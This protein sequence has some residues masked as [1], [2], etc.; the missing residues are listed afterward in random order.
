MV[1]NS[2]VCLYMSQNDTTLRECVKKAQ[3]IIDSGKAK[4][5]LDDFIRLSNEETP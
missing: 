5:L 2:A 1:L 3:R 4:A